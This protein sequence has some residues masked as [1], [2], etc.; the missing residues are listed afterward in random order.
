MSRSLCARSLLDRIA[1][2]F[3]AGLFLAAIGLIGCQRGE[4]PALLQQRQKLVLA[5]E[6]AGAVGIVQARQVATDQPQPLVVVGRVG[7]GARGTWDEGRAA[8]L[9]A[10]PSATAEQLAHAHGS[11]H[12]NC[13]FCKEH[14]H[15]EGES[16]PQVTA[17]VQF[18]D[19][20]G[21]VLPIDARRLLAL[22]EN[23]LVVVQGKGHIDALGNLVV[24]ADG[25]FP[26]P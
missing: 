25:L 17:L 23:Q 15:E 13:P 19:S 9:V 12:D 8:F 18:V 3:A 20:A 4:D 2:Q 26:R 1:R 6:P 11:D 10:D 14:H 5:A 22:Q 16:H 7:G 21:Q 24:T